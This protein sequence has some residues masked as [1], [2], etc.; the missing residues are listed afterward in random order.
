M[1]DLVKVQRVA[2][3]ELSPNRYRV[4]LDGDTVGPVL[5]KRAAAVVRRWLDGGALDDLERPAQG[6]S[7]L[8]RTLGKV[9]E[10]WEAV[11]DLLRNGLR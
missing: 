7:K 5:T 6:A 4:Q 2:L 1:T 3:L 8:Q 9:D 10:A 11:D